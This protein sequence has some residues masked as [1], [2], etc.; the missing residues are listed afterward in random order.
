MDEE[1]IQNAEEQPKEKTLEQ[2]FEERFQQEEAAE[3]EAEKDKAYLLFKARRKFGL[4]DGALEGWKRNHPLGVG[5]TWI[6]GKPYIYRA[7]SL[8]EYLGILEKNPEAADFQKA[9]ASRALLYPEINDNEYITSLAGLPT[10]LSNAILQTSGFEQTIA[11]P[12]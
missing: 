12:V 3:Q 6:G 8:G 11:I 9:V 2:E 4:A 10:S 7:L 1:Q 5:M